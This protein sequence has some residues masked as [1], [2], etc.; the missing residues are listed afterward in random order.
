MGGR[1][2]MVTV[3]RRESTGGCA[4]GL[5]PAETAPTSS[6]NS[7]TSPDAG[8]SCCSTASSFAWT[9]MASPTSP[10]CAGARGAWKGDRCGRTPRPG[11]VDRLDVLHHDGLCPRSVRRFLSL[12]RRPDARFCTGNHSFVRW[13]AAC[14]SRSRVGGTAGRSVM[15]L[16][17]SKAGPGSAP[18]PDP[19]SSAYAGRRRGTST[20][21]PDLC[22]AT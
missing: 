6:P 18:R 22:P 4:S 8:T 21:M 5:A 15:G 20:C 17:D 12:C 10:H 11:D 13:G 3:L 1:G 2:G 19:P 9:R 14:R 7:P 16:G